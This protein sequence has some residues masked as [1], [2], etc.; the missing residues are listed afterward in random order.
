MPY[1]RKVLHLQ[2]DATD[3]LERCTF[4]A[5]QQVIGLLPAGSQLRFRGEA[6]Q[7]VVGLLHTPCLAANSPGVPPEPT[8]SRRRVHG[9]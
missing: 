4:A 2:V 9:G 6:F 7:T 5:P 1:S 3:R 8:R